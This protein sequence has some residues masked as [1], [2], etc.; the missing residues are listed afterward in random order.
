MLQEK[1]DKNKIFRIFIIGMLCLAISQSVFAQNNFEKELSIGVNGGTTISSVNFVGSKFTVRQNQLVQA[2][3]GL[4]IRFISEKNIGIQGEINYSQR[5]WKE[6]DLIDTEFHY[7]RQ[8]N[9][10][11]LPV[12]THLYFNA[13]ERFRVVFNFGP[14]LGYFLSE[15]D[16]DLSLTTDNNKENRPYITQEVQRKFDWGLCFGGGV[17]LCTGAGNFVLDGRYY[18]GLSDIFNNSKSDNFASSS[19]QIIS[20]KL[21]YFYRLRTKN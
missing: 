19:N 13:G 7:S 2:V 11:E 16:L 12:L 21:T 17:E 20:V 4:S 1:L 18:Y 9:Y 8:L 6:Y 10:L 3:G 5:G 15:K 14:Q